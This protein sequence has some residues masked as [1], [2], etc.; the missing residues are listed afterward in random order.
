MIDPDNPMTK[1]RKPGRPFGSKA[2]PKAPEPDGPAPVVDK[3]VRTAG[4]RIRAQLELN[5]RKQIQA[6]IDKLEKK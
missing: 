6:L 5:R 3:P 2:K 1:K 4:E